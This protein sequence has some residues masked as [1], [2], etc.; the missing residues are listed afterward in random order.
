LTHA[1]AV[2]PDLATA[3][4]GLGVAY[5]TQGDTVRA[6]A[7]WRKALELRPGYR[8]AQFNLDRLAK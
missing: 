3:H 4:N 5:A 7:E 2:N 8:D 1:I 6:A